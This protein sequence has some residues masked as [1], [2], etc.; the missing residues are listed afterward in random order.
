MPS[1]CVGIIFISYAL[2]V[3]YRPFVDPNLDVATADF[4][5]RVVYVS[6]LTQ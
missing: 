1:L 4:R 6:C 3:H 2:Q 5:S